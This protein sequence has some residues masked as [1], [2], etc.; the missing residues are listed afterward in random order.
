MIRLGEVKKAMN[1]KY[2]MNKLCGG[3]GDTAKKGQLFQDAKGPPCSSTQ[4][5][6]HI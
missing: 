6:S 4:N 2:A 3:N 1:T 5:G